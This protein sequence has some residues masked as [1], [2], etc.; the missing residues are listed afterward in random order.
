MKEKVFKPTEKQA[1]YNIPIINSR[2]NHVDILK[3][4]KEDIKEVENLQAYENIKKEKVTFS[5]KKRPR[6]RA[7]FTID[8]FTWYA[9]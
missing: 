6:E 5:R 8:V 4:N 2:F 7:V 3:G 9:A 1:R